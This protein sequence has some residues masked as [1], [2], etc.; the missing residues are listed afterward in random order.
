MSCV[1]FGLRGQIYKKSPNSML[2]NAKITQIEANLFTFRSI[3]YSMKEKLQSLRQFGIRLEQRE[4]F[5]ILNT[6]PLNSLRFVIEET[7]GS[8]CSDEVH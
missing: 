1:P 3:V 6:I 8:K 4:L 7:I 5:S 2:I